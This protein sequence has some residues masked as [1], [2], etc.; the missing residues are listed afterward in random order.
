MPDLSDRPGAP[1]R[2]GSGAVTLLVI[3]AGLLLMAGVSILGTGASAAADPAAMPTGVA[4]A[5]AVVDACTPPADVTDQDAMITVA[6]A[7]LQAT[8]DHVALVDDHRYSAGKFADQIALARSHN[9][10]LSVVVLGA[11]VGESAKASGDGASR[12]A[13]GVQHQVGGTVVVVT[14]GYFG[15]S[16]DEFSQSDLDRARDAASVGDAPQ[17]VATI[18]DS[19]TAKPFPWLLAVTATIA[20]LV[21]GA[22]AGG[23]WSRRRRRHTDQ[24]A[25]ADLT[26]GLAARVA[27]LAPTI[28]SITDE[29][30]VVGRP[31]LED[32]FAQ[33]AGDYNELRARLGAPLPDR[34]AVNEAAARVQVLTDGLAAI[35]SEVT[36]ALD[37]A[38]GQPDRGAPPAS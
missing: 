31:D 35:D 15:I 30:D 26:A 9:V 4:Q 7:C 32:R 19:L 22:F 23:L 10:S 1:G 37:R 29:V 3:A 12:V 8:T 17:V 33:A 14:P 11:E 38:G 5:A 24:E 36:A 13:D 18:V 28:V 34:A 25:L 27:D 6:V 21:L 16:S 20:V 2:I